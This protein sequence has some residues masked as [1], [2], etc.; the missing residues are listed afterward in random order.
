MTI[1]SDVAPKALSR[2]P[3]E[4]IYANIQPNLESGQSPQ[5][6]EALSKEKDGLIF[7]SQSSV[8]RAGT[9]QPRCIPSQK[10]LGKHRRKKRE[11]GGDVAGRGRVTETADGR[12]LNATAH[13]AS[14]PG[15]PERPAGGG[16][17]RM[18]PVGHANESAGAPPHDD[19]AASAG[20][21]CDDRS[22]EAAIYSQRLLD[23]GH[24]RSP[25]PSDDASA[26]AM[27]QKRVSKGDAEAINHLGNQYFHGVHGL[28]RDATRAIELWT[29]AAELGSADAHF[30]LGDTYYKGDGAREDKPRGVRHWQEAAMKGHVLSRHMLGYAEFNEENHELAVQHW[31]ISAKLGD[32][33][34][35]NAIK[36]MFMEGEATKAQYA[37]ALRGYG[38]AAEE[39][40]SHQR[41]KA[42]E[43]GIY[44][45]LRGKD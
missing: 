39:M 24:E 42:M 45:H 3:I 32:E 14:K 8:S 17:V 33:K 21:D 37:E 12:Q 9:D 31:M 40:K 2:G 28:A 1:L 26:L 30:D 35:L 25:H 10:K 13:S 29:E 20:A 34:S 38:D 44:N 22:A 43:V 6:R 16:A 11:E 36:V 23:E 15:S 41:E 18:E 7:L 19:G 5:I 27:I 4:M